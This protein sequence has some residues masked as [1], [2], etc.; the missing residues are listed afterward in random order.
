MHKDL[1][2]VMQMARDL[3]VPMFTAGTAAQLF[4]AGKT[5]YPEVITGLLHGHLKTLSVKN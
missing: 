1:G 5:K 3:G 4:Q 2:I